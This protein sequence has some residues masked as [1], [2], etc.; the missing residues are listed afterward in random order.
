MNWETRNPDPQLSSA[1]EALDQ[2]YMDRLMM[3]ARRS[4]GARRSWPAAFDERTGGASTTRM[5]VTAEEA[6]E[7]HDQLRET[8]ERVVGTHHRYADRRDPKLRP[9]DAVPVEFVLLGY[10][11]LDAPPLPDSDEGDEEPALGEESG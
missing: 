4:L 1:A 6:G 3:R 10:P 11:I 7:L 5:F 9:P 8:F 2:V